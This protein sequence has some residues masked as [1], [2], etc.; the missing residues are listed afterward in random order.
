M[1]KITALLLILAM[2]AAMLAGCG[3][4]EEEPYVPTGDALLMEGE[5]PESLE[6]EEVTQKVTL[7]YNPDRS[8]NPLIG[9]SQNN[10]AVMSLIY[11]GLFAINSRGEA[12]PIL[13]SG[14]KVEPSNMIYTFYIEEKATFSDG[15]P[16]TVEDVLASYQAARESDYYSGRFKYYVAEIRQS[17]DGTG[18][19]FSLNAPY[20]NLPMLLDVPIVKAEEVA[21]THPLGTGP[22]TCV[23]DAAGAYLMKVRSWWT[24]V[25]TPVR[26]DTVKLVEATSDTQVRDEFQFGEVSLAVTNPLSD[27]FAEYSCDYELWNVDS[28]VFLYLGCNVQWSDYFDDGVL[29]TVLTYA[30]DRETIIRE[31]YHDQ[32]QLATLAVSPSTPYYNEML[33]SRYGYD[34]MKFI[35]KTASWPI[36]NDPTTDDDK[37]VLLVNS[38]DSARL[39]TA[40]FIAETL[41]E[42]GIPTGT[43]ECSGS[44]YVDVLKANNWD[45]YLGQTRLPANM[46]M[47][48][49]FRNWG[50]LS[51]GGIPNDTLLNACK[52]CLE[53][54]GSY[55]SFLQTL[56]EDGRI[57]P[58]LFGYHSVYAARGLF[59]DL[60][61][62]RD[63][64][65]F[66][67]MG[68]T[69]ADIQVANVYE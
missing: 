2:L 60:D 49:F 48:E 4:A 67:S 56:A 9:Y 32:A 59:Y 40:R 24:D 62:A 30:L 54:S 58:I 55:Y 14:F 66:Y 15:S 61:P 53:N 42:L 65:F 44:N 39:R 45:I 20:E 64:P 52:D 43:L 33:A 28:G 31:N 1:K 13:C 46:D 25:K 29:R 51:W 69:M 17:N 7:A 36:P 27:A 18:I 19:T 16:V 10:R 21:A 63:N 68:K 11:Q 23:E 12:E 37:M 35:E 47:T 34:P 5:D 26:C 41:T 6:E 22:Y 57:I 38:D 8:M 50:N 3:S